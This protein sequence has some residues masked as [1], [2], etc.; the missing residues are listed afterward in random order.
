MEILTQF[1]IIAGICMG[2]DWIASLLPIPF[3]GSVIAMILLFILLG[4]KWIKEEQIQEVGDFLLKNMAF[5]F[6]PAG[7]SVMNYFDL[8]KESIVPFIFICVITLILTFAVT[9]TT[10]NFVMK[11][12]QKKENRENES[13]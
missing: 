8:L 11:I 12:Q 9:A 13:C 3:P 5:F 10:V 1:A 4:I 6:V 2:G 7:V